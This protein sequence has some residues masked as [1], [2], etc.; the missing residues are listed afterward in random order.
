MAKIYFYK[1]TSDDGGAPCVTGDLLSLAICKPMIRSTAEIG[2]LIFGFAA[3]SLHKDN[4]LIYVAS[5]TDKLCDGKYYKDYKYAKRSDCIYKFEAGRYFWKRGSLYHNPEDL[6]HDLGR[7][8][9]Y[10]RA[11]VL[12][13]EDF[14]YF[15]KAGSAEYITRFSEVHSAVERLGQGHRV[16]HT[17]ALRNEFLQMKEWV[18]DTCEEK[19]I[20]EPTSKPS[21]SV[22]HRSK[23]CGVVRV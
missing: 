16:W 11:N 1:L 6:E 15:G 8:P 20:G 4:R 13:S 2:D 19:K 9:E 14:R 23:S 12:L 18:W 22:C 5:V 10:Q 3:D 21:R 17:P 7:Y